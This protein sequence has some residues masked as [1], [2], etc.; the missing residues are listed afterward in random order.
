MIVY[1]IY[2]V[3]LT[4]HLIIS[5]KR[6]A[7]GIFTAGRAIVPTQEKNCPTIS[8]KESTA[9][10]TQALKLN[11]LQWKNQCLKQANIENKI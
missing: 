1:R 4:L 9:H 2:A 6:W 3:P 8:G 5:P 7:N 11:F 10:H